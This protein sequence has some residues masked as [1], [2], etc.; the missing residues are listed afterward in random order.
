MLFLV[1]SLVAVEDGSLRMDGSS[2]K[3]LKDSYYEIMTELPIEDGDSFSFAH[4]R[5]LAYYSLLESKNDPRAYPK[6]AL[7]ALDG[8][9]PSEV[10][11]L[12]GVLKKKRRVLEQAE[13]ERLRKEAAV[14]RAK[15]P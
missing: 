5:V 1:C 8:K 12:Y 10:I 7:K 11:E 13:I 14:L 4:I 3:G 15:E 2:Q 9:S 6:G